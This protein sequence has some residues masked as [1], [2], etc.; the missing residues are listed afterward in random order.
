LLFKG[1]FVILFAMKNESEKLE[2][3]TNRE[4]PALTRAE[5]VEERSIVPF[6]P[7]HRYLAE[8]RHY[9]I[10]TRDEEHRLA[11]DFKEKGSSQA[12]YQLV[13]S[14]LRLVVLIARQYQKAF[15][16]LLDLIQ[17]GNIGLM[18]AVKNFDPYR[19]IRFPSYAVWWI[20]AYI[21]R[22]ILNNWRLV[23]IGTTQAQRK[24]FFNLQKE[25]NRLEA[26]GLDPSPKLLAQGLNVKEEEVVEMDQR[27]SSR[28]V[29]VDSP[30][31]NREESS[32]LDLLVDEKPRPDEEV[33]NAETTFLIREKLATFSSGL[34]DKE[35]YIF[36]HRLMSEEPATLQEIGERYGISRE[37]TRQ[38]EERLKNRLKDYLRKE[39]PD[40]GD[41]DIGYPLRRH[42]PPA[43]QRKRHKSGVVRES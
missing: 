18:E 1:F 40:L 3:D 19:G 32:L 30:I 8:I 2:L 6:D 24:L 15:Q 29:S 10:L 7:L 42:S 9:R 16:D 36:Q 13:T 14:N 35:H 28:D 27:L 22:Y 12:A 11:V 37:R 5:A 31:G 33:G 4:E 38:I 26:E 34:R 21:I 39:I 43:P 17:E 23:K 41:I 25:K 20:R